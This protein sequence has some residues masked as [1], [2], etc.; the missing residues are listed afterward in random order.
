MQMPRASRKAG[1]VISDASGREVPARS[2]GLHATSSCWGKQG[3]SL[4][5]SHIVAVV[6]I[7]NGRGVSTPTNAAG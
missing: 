5:H 2:D 4:K 6:M 3:A 1:N 7:A